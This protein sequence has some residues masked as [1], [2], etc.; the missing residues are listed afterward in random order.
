[1]V[2]IVHQDY[3]IKEASNKYSSDGT[4]WE[5]FEKIIRNLMVGN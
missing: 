3:F 1:M 5:K 4:D 2:A